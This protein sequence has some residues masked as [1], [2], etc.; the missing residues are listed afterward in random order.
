MLNIYQERMAKPNTSSKWV[1]WSMNHRAW[2]AQKLQKCFL[3]SIEKAIWTILCDTHWWIFLNYQ[4]WFFHMAPLNWKKVSWMVMWWLFDYSSLIALYPCKA[5]SLQIRACNFE[6][7]LHS[8]FLC[9]HNC[10]ILLQ[11]SSIQELQQ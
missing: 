6:L 4:T 11:V 5:R 2:F 1:Q 9:V 10:F 7:L 3:L 8:F